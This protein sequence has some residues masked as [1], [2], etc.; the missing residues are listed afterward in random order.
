MRRSLANFVPGLALNPEIALM[1]LALM[2]ALGLATGL[3]PALNALRLKVA[4]GLG[5]G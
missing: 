4:A 3:M 2:V 1:A 5:R